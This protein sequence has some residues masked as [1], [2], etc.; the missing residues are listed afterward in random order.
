MFMDNVNWKC[1]K[2]LH[3][4][5]STESLTL[6]CFKNPSGVSIRHWVTLQA[7]TPF[8]KAIQVKFS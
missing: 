5:A 3:I 8:F 6:K 1:K 7:W 4:A 2:E